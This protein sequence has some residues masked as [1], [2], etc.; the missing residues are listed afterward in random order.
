MDVKVTVEMSQEEEDKLAGI[1]NYKGADLS[2]ALEPYASAAVEEYLRMF[3]G[4]KVFTRGSDFREYRLYLLIKYAYSDC[5]PDEQTVSDLFSSTAS[6]SR[7]LIRSVISKYQYDLVTITE[8]SFK[9]AITEAKYSK[10]EDCY[11]ITTGSENLISELNLTIAAIDG[12][13]PPITKRPKTV[14]T[15]RLPNSSRERLA[16]LFGIELPK[17]AK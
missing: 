13:L 6:Q 10:K 3:L 1:L 14:S 12:T 11:L 2:K 15:Y 8:K 7:S 17:E 16:R 9:K 4:Q 5:I